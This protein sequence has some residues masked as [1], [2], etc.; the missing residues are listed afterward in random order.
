M[1]YL[2]ANPELLGA[3]VIFSVAA[4]V[5]MLFW[6]A[7]K[8]FQ[9]FLPRQETSEQ[10]DEPQDEQVDVFAEEEPK[11]EI[12]Y[13][14][15]GFSLVFYLQGGYWHADLLMG[16]YRNQLP[17]NAGTSISQVFWEAVQHLKVSRQQ[18]CFNA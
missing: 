15:D 4:T 1:Q 12:Q 7:V 18:S 5:I 13:H 11:G 6:F 9:H 8:T 2:L 16:D 14:L 17:V 3:I 10:H